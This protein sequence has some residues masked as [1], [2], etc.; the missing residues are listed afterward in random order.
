MGYLLP[1][2]L[3]CSTNTLKNK[4]NHLS[5]PNTCT[6]TAF[7]IVC[8]VVQ[9]VQTGSEKREVLTE[10]R[11]PLPVLVAGE[12]GAQGR[13]LHPGR[14]RL[15]RLRRLRLQRGQRE[16]QEEEDGKVG[17]GR[18]LDDLTKRVRGIS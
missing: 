18:H 17:G 2:P 7:I 12:D 13:P 10:S 15:L 4:T 5:L 1:C 11:A 8:N 9:L 6:T 14:G 3:T 16:E